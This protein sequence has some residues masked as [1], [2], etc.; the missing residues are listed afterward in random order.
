MLL[1]SYNKAIMVNRLIS[2]NLELWNK[3]LSKA[4]SQGRTLVAVLRRFLE[5]WVND[6]IDLKW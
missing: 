5:L 4:N 1:S 6:E 3:A 2:V